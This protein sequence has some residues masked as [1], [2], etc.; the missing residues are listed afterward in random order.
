MQKESNQI[1]NISIV[2]GVFDSV[3]N[4]K[5]FMNFLMEFEQMIGTYKSAIKV[6]TTQLDLLNADCKRRG[7]R[8]PI[9]SY[10]SRIKEPMSILGKLERKNLPFTLEAIR[11]NLNDIAGVRII[12]EYI[13]DIYTIRD[14]LCVLPHGTILQEKDYIKNPKENGY[15]SLHFVVELQLPGLQEGENVKCEIQLRTTAMD[16]W[17]GLEHNMRYKKNRQQSDQINI[18]LKRCADTLFETDVQMQRIAEEIGLYS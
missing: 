17:A 2:E 5:K 12:C 18:D 16:S 7:Q 10:S 4:E 9:R 14:I 3:S 1:D 8:S 15:R 6:M 13:K 11:E